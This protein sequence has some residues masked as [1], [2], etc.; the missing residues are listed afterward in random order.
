[1]LLNVCVSVPDGEGEEKSVAV[2]V[3]CVGG[4]KKG[5]G[6]EWLLLSHA[7]SC[8]SA[9]ERQRGC[10]CVPLTPSIHSFP[11]FVCHPSDTHTQTPTHT[12]TP[13]MAGNE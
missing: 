1:M 9:S 8:C 4:G 2:H 13:F 11:L 10:P 5:V 6:Y 12:H 7:G 3:L